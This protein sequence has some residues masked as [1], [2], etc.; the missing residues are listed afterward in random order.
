M[1]RTSRR[2]RDTW[3][4]ALI[5]AVL[6]FTS[7]RAAA[8]PVVTTVVGGPEVVAVAVDPNSGATYFATDR[9]GAIY[10][11][12]IG[13]PP[14]LVAGVAGGR[15]DDGAPAAQA[16][17]FPGR[18]GLAV[19]ATGDLYFSEPSLH[20]IRQIDGSGTVTTIAG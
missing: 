6:L 13:G 1:D 20:R 11:L 5:V 19:D 9:P 2:R 8:Q 18:N 17:V 4:R 10:R 3:G 16:A 12:G 14:V 15:T 7:R